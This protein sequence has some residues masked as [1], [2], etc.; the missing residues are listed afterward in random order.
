MDKITNNAKNNNIDINA[1]IERMTRE[2]EARNSGGD[3]K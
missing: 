2:R 3:K 1:T